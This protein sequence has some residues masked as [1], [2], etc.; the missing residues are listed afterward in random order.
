[1]LRPL[2]PLPLL[3]GLFW[4]REWQR[5]STFAALLVIDVWRGH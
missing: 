3:R 4:G 5:S 1:M 2:L